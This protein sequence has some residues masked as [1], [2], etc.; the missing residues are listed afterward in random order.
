VPAELAIVIVTYN[1][2]PVIDGLL[3]S[4][5]AA[6]GGI[7]ADVVVVDNGSS[8]DTVERVARRSDCRVVRSANLG[9]SAGINRGVAEAAEAPAVLILNPDVRLEAKCVTA[10]LSGLTRPGAGIAVPQIRSASGALDRTLRRYPSLPRAMGL[11]GTKIPLFA[12]NLGHDSDYAVPRAVDWATGAV[13]LISRAC[14]ETVGQW[15]ESYF[16]YSEETDYC[17]RARDLG[18]HT[19][20]VPE[21]VV[22]HLAGASGRNDRTHSMQA[23]NRVRFYRRRH[24]LVASWAYFA[25]TVL[26]ELSWV[27]RGNTV[28]RAAVRALL[29]PRHRPAELGCSNALMPS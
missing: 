19:W 15:D 5:P 25:L 27:A 1:S 14:W 3:D 8:D 7:V 9:Y 2:A 16:L 21:A 6:L 11:N 4:I 22:V 13:M 26:T 17:A 29:R 10:L 20:Y 24:S 23:V 12:E 18:L 28:S